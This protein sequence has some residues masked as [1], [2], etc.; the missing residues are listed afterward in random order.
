VMVWEWK[1]Y[2]QYQYDVWFIVGRRGM[3]LEQ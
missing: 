2:Q 3:V 1:Q